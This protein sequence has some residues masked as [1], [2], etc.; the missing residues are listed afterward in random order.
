MRY[1]AFVDSRPA[2]AHVSHSEACVTMPGEGSAASAKPRILHLSGDFP[3]TI[4]RFKTPVIRTLLDLTN[5][6]F[7]HDVISLNRCSPRISDFARGLIVGVGTPRLTLSQRLFRYGRT[8]TYDAPARGIFH[9]TMLRQLGDRL[10]DDFAGSPP[11][12]L[13]VGHKLSIE[14]IVARRVAARLGVPFAISIQGDTDTKVL[15]ARP[16]LA[17]ELRAVFHEAAVVFPFAPWSLRKVEERLGKRGGPVVFLPCPT[18]LDTPLPPRMGGDGLV[19]VFHLKNRRRKNLRGL[20][21]AIRL[22]QKEDMTP[23]LGIIGGGENDD[24][25]RS[26]K[27]VRHLDN[28]AFEG[29]LD[30]TALRQ[31]LNRATGFV[32]PSLRES[33]GLVF[34]EALFAGLPIIYPK[35]QSVDGFFDDAP[36]AIPVDA[37][38]PTAIAA[39]IRKLVLEE[40][41]LKSELRRWQTSRHAEGFRRAAVGRKFAA[42]LM[43]SIQDSQRKF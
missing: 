30:R 6:A 13:I 15:A 21:A 26:R 40:E 1:R 14:G 34:V 3:D 41:G 16:D 29:S 37:K 19:T 22:L 36:F 17:N 11:P 7:E 31:R 42:G 23:T 8:L 28:V 4:D 33:F 39:A 38:D 43:S 27:I 20:V 10:A 24:L 5:D 9:A 12:D 25:E 18:D 32:L 2:H 35:G